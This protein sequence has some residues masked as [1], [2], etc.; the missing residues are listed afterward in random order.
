[1]TSGFYLNGAHLCPILGHPTYYV[2]RQGQVY[3]AHT[4]R[5]LKDSNCAGY[6]NVG[7]AVNGRSKKFKVHR[8]VALAFLPNPQNKPD[9]NHKDGNKAN[10]CLGN[11]EWCTEKENVQHA[12]QTGLFRRSKSTGR[13]AARRLA[14]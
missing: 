7:L 14:Y 12:V 5:I 2:S 8:L 1:M 3:S 6:R 4:D 9:V 13:K 11:L 10:N